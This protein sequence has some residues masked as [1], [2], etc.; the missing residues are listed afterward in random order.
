MNEAGCLD[1]K[2]GDSYDDYHAVC[3]VSY[4][5]VK[6]MGPKIWVMVKN[7]W[8]PFGH[9]Q[10]GVMEEWLHRKLVCEMLVPVLPKG[11]AL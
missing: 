10:I 5:D 7:S 4:G 1:H 11:V 3:I 8:K 9:N 2:A 6:A